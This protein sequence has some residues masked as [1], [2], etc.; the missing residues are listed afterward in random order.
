[1]K[2]IQRELMTA[3][4]DYGTVKGIAKP[5]LHQPGA[6]KLSNF[7]GFAVEQFVERV[8]GTRKPQ[9]IGDVEIVT[10]EWTSPP[11]A[12]HVRSLVHLGDFTGPVVAQGTGEANSWEEKYRY[13]F[14]KPL[15]PNC[16]HDM[17]RGGKTGKMAGKWF[18]PGYDGGCWTAIG[19]DEKN[20]DGTPKIPPP[21]KV[22]NDNPYSLAETLVQMAAK[23][24]FVAA[25]RRATGTS[26]L[27]TQDEDSPSVQGQA[28]DAGGNADEPNI[29]S[30]ST[31]GIQVGVGAKTTQ[32][33]QV[34]HD[35]LKVLVKEKELN[36]AKIASLLE[37][38]FA[39]DVEPT[40]AASSAAVKTLDGDQMGKLLNAIETGEIPAAPPPAEATPGEPPQDT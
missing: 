23:R 28:D 6:E 33:T 29:E 37:R 20:D 15:C 16:G 8:E 19:V 35:R 32:A 18:C 25:I 10:D 4:E 38:I 39:M 36:G 7:Y 9:R 14:A 30:A 22:D 11:L 21:G 5:F 2:I 3:G 24:S 26:G 1:M 13:T 34:Q 40:G 17:K 27:F 31:A 12:Y